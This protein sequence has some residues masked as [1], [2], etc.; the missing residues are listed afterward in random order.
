LLQPVGGDCQGITDSDSLGKVDGVLQVHHCVE[1]K[2]D[3]GKSARTAEV[4]E[5]LIA[6]HLFLA[7]LTPRGPKIDEY[8]LAAKVRRRDF[9]NT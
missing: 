2:S 8:D 5:L 9:A 6:G 7:G 1:L 4:E 3:D